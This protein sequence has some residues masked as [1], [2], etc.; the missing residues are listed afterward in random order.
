MF[1]INGIYHY[2][3]TF[4]M[5]QD[6]NIRKIS[7]EPIDT[8]ILDDEGL[9]YQDENVYLFYAYNA[10][11]IVKYTY[12]F[13]FK[14]GYI[15]YYSGNRFISIPSSSI[16]TVNIFIQNKEL[17]IHYKSQEK[18][19]S[20]D[21]SQSS[22]NFYLPIRYF[23]NGIELNNYNYD[24]YIN[25]N[26]NIKFSYKYNK[27]ITVQ[28]THFLTNNISL[29]SLVDL[30]IQSLSIS[31]PTIKYALLQNMD[32]IHYFTFYITKKTITVF[33]TYELFNL[34]ILYNNLKLYY[35]KEILQIPV[36][37]GSVSMYHDKKNLFGKY[38]DIYVVPSTI[39]M[40]VLLML[41]GNNVN[42]LHKNPVF[43]WQRIKKQ[44]FPIIYT[45]L[46]VL[47]TISKLEYL[48]DGPYCKIYSKQYD[49]Y[50]YTNEKITIR[51][52]FPNNL[53]RISKE[54]LT[55]NYTDFPL[56][57][58]STSPVQHIFLNMP[59]YNTVNLY[60][61]KNFTIMEDPYVNIKK[62]DYLAVFIILYPGALD[63]KELLFVGN[64]Y[65]LPIIIKRICIDKD[66]TNL[67][68][69]L[70]KINKMQLPDELIYTIS[71]AINNY[72]SNYSSL[73]LENI[74]NNYDAQYNMSAEFIL[75]CISHNY[76]NNIVLSNIKGI[77][78]KYNLPVKLKKQY[79]PVKPGII[80]YL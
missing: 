29:G 2:N 4:D 32:N 11:N 52:V 18:N 6:L 17:H 55:T 80:F 54:K 8:P 57:F 72:C 63:Y 36:L 64:N 66:I 43:V 47:P 25:N 34:I 27:T 24:S 23:L 51:S 30:F 68:F 31:T 60:I 73:V 46:I 33:I 5:S 38:K 35:R 44:L 40:Y 13:N 41:N 75:A 7:M 79:K 28:L 39:Q 78:V 74:M 1:Y 62:L 9:L 12:S 50:I 70:S 71:Q 14:N 53:Y 20:L 10:E 3:I 77:F 19:I 22:N 26:N 69:V 45:D 49:D 61:S 15:C 56:L 59:Y 37:G 76:I 16:F 42:I 67:N 21:L 48:L 58:P 65:L